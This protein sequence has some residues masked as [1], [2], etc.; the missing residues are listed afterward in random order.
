MRFQGRADVALSD[1]GRAE[2][3]S[4]Q[5]PSEFKS[6][7]LVS[8]PLTRAVETARL[9]GPESSV[10]PE[11]AEMSWG[12][13]EGMRL[14]ELGLDMWTLK[15]RQYAEGL[16]FHGP[17]GESPRDVQCRILPWLNSLSSPTVAVCHNWVILALYSLATG[18]DMKTAP[19]DR[20]QRA[21]FHEF[22]VLSGEMEIVR[23]NVP[24][25]TTQKRVA[26]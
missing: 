9:L 7:D 18:W 1:A 4:W 12:A 24:L 10:I 16:D 13:W 25:N 5:L 26:A 6:F 3:R 19:T 11:L 8:S 23:L 15:S 20:L 21:T 17:D 14:D 22:R 2:V